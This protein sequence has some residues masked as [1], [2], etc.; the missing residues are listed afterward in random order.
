[1]T[2]ASH[3]QTIP[4][5][6]MSKV[7]VEEIASFCQFRDLEVYLGDPDTGFV[8]VNGD[9]LKQNSYTYG[10]FNMLS[11]L[12]HVAPV[13]EVLSKASVFKLRRPGLQQSLSRED[14]E[15]TLKHFQE[16]VAG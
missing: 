3:E 5:G 14:F 13:K 1:M 9:G 11:E 10:R 4:A 12:A 6:S 8:E 15:K 2:D 16:L 7:T